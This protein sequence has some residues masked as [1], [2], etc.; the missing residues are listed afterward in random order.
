MAITIHVM[1]VTKHLKVIKRIEW[2]S[3][4]ISW[5]L[6]EGND[7]NKAANGREKQLMVIAK[8]VMAVTKHFKVIPMQ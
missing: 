4:N 5:L 1:A 2:T 3:H 6:K 7:Y 8:H